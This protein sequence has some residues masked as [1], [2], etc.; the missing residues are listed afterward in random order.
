MNIK[1][2]KIISINEKELIVSCDDGKNRKFVI[3]R[4]FEDDIPIGMRE[5]WKLLRQEEFKNA[6]ILTG[7]IIW[8]GRCEILSSEIEKYLE[9]INE[10]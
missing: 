3:N 9:V 7:D 10:Y 6:Y 8:E 5:T 1:A 4:M 2:L